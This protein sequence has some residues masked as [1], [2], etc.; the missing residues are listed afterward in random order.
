MQTHLITILKKIAAVN[1]VEKLAAV[2]LS[3]PIVQANCNSNTIAFFDEAAVVRQ[4]G[5]SSVVVG[6]SSPKE[7]EG[8][9][10]S[11]TFPL[12]DAIWDEADE[13]MRRAA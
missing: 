9:V 7:I 13:R 6:A 1:G 5:V 8:N 4:P 10:F 11:A 3:Q 12:P 2:L